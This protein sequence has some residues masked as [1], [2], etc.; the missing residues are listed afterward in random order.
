MVY[1]VQHLST[2][3]DDDIVINGTVQECNKI[4][5]QSAFSVINCFVF[6]TRQT[7]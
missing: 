3:V 4:I 5:I 1:N 6:S 2:G 7:C